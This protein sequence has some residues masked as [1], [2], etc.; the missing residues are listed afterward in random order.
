MNE[1]LEKPT[2]TSAS[3]LSSMPSHE[4][5]YPSCAHDTCGAT[6]RTL[7]VRDRDL[8][9]RISQRVRRNGGGYAAGTS[10]SENDKKRVCQL[11]SAP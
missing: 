1:I 6:A 11:G 7:R 10:V 3:Y 9:R 2:Q 8:C 5:K 4:P